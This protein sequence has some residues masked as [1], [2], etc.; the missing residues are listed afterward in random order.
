MANND[1]Q[2]K[3]GADGSQFNQGINAML[4]ALN[5]LDKETM[6]IGPRIADAFK[7]PAAILTAAATAVGA[8][9]AY[10]A[11]TSIDAADKLSE[12][13]QKVGLSAQA[14][15]T[16]EYAA[17]MSGVEVEGLH[18]SLTKMSVKVNDAATGGE[19]SAQ[20]FTALGVSIKNADGSVK[21]G[22]V[23]LAD[24]AGKFAVMPD[25]INK[26]AAAVELFGKSGA[27]IIP[28]LNQGR[29]GIQQ[30]RDEARKLGLEIS[31][32]TATAANEF[33]DNLDRMK[34]A[35]VGVSNQL[36][37]ELIPAFLSISNAMLMA[38]TSGNALNTT[39]RS[40]GNTLKGLI[41]AA[42]YTYVGVM[43]VA[44]SFE[45][46]GKQIVAF[47]NKE[48]HLMGI[49]AQQSVD[50]LK[51]IGQEANE[52]QKRLWSNGPN[53]QAALSATNGNSQALL[54]LSGSAKIATKSMADLFGDVM[55]AK[56]K[57]GM[58]TILTNTNIKMGELTYLADQSA[59]S[60]E[61]L[62]K[63]IPRFDSVKL[64]D[65][66]TIGYQQMINELDLSNAELLATQGIMADESRVAYSNMFGDMAAAAANF[67]DVTGQKSAEFF[68]ISKAFQI[69]QATMATYESAVNAFNSLSKIPFVGPYLGAAAAAAAVT[70][71]ISNVAKI[72]ATQPGGSVSGG[73]AISLPGNS[74]AVNM[75]SVAPSTGG[76]S[77]TVNIT[78]YGNV[79]D[80]DRF[81]RELIPSIQRAI[82][83]GVS[84][85]G[86]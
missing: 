69:G 39:A 81:A 55:V 32:K 9:F 57:A 1:Y 51:V 85:Q 80:Q 17:K 35:G 13:A 53:T 79:V 67:Y 54:N 31:D 5:K 29:D 4:G 63:A 66:G 71:G 47:N 68:A 10:M 21:A 6:G 36:M 74:G 72:A 65:T 83:D 45:M 33:N 34:L 24:I 76:G 37:T 38:T 46:L 44:I 11:K 20:A 52:F 48:Y 86:V 62:G 60:F 75:P 73:G 50:K 22:D 14:L 40:I 28:F 27:Q 23:I 61:N 12:N 42:N 26:T 77:R 7:S 2:A 59:K 56:Q 78:I 82:N 25:G 49:I 18:T 30:L 8:G 43:D 70:F 15:S 64:F 58:L 41:S 16:L 3:F 84:L 19:K